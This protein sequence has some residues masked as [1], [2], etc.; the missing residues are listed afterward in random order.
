MPLEVKLQAPSGK[1][2]TQPVGLFI[3]NEFV[4]AEKNDSF[5]VLDPSTGKVITSV[6][7]ASEND[8]DKAVA[9]A[10]KAFKPW[11]KTGGYSRGR[12]L[13][14]LADLL[15]QNAELLATIEALDSGKVY[16]YQAL[17][18]IHAAIQCYRYYAGYADKIEGKSIEASDSRIGYTL[19]E[20]L[21]VCG[22]IIPWNYPFLMA[23]WKVA[24]A[25]AAGNCIVLKLAENT[26]LSMLYFGKLVAEAGFPAGVVNIING[27]GRVAGAAL[28]AHTDVDKI[29]FTGST[30]TGK[31]I[32]KLA[33]S[34]LKNITLECGGKSPMIIFEDAD[35]ELAA[36]E[37][38]AA[39]MA[40]QGQTCTAMSRYYVQES[41]YDKF[42]EIYKTH[43]E[44]HSKVDLP[45]EKGAFHGPQISE[46]QHKKIMDY[47]ASGKAEG[48]RVVLGGNE[49]EKFKGGLYVQPT[50]FSDV[51]DN[52]KIMRE[53]IFGPVG[54]IAKFKTEEEAIERANDSEYGLAA[55][56]F[57]RDIG[58]ATRVA[59]ELESG[60]VFIN[61]GN[62][63]DIRMPFGGYKA[64]GIGRELGGDGIEI[65][66]QV[67]AVH[68][69]L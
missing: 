24:P 29:A 23:A 20:P 17:P 54:A 36:T 47:I 3:N 13:S 6:Q 12:L 40:N 64:S 68:V 9:A 65:Y 35:L 58:R 34:N 8:V 60:Q 51:H 30:A 42:I 62:L 1:E 49:P 19:R 56:V 48:A 2:W 39:L 31:T 53:E 25:V 67:K 43:V 57:T 59:A 66:T 15:E 69:K 14:K 11:K 41:V 5:E 18:N 16:N 46:I 55:S 38:H 28:A 26:P 52:M 4:A 37:A 27:L 7:S 10:R 61:N 21:G 44:K 50:L 33:A 32:M 45:F 22:Q 63:P